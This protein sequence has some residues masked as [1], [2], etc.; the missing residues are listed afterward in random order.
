M[1]QSSES[2]QPAAAL[3]PTLGSSEIPSA[4]GVVESGVSFDEILAIETERQLFDAIADVPALPVLPTPATLPIENIQEPPPVDPSLTN[5]NPFFWNLDTVDLELN[6]QGQIDPSFIQAAA[7]TD[8]S[9]MPSIESLDAKN[10][11]LVAN[12]INRELTA[13]DGLGEVPDIILITLAAN[14]QE[15]LRDSAAT[16]DFSAPTEA[17]P[18][19]VA[20]FIDEDALPKENR[21]DSSSREI[22]LSPS[23]QTVDESAPTDTLGDALADTSATDPDGLSL[24]NQ[25]DSQ[26]AAEPSVGPTSDLAQPIES[27]SGSVANNANTN[28]AELAQATPWNAANPASAQDSSLGFSPQSRGETEITQVVTDNLVQQV[29]LTEQGESKQLRLQLHPA[30]LGQVILQVDWENDSLKV[31]LLASEMAATE[32]LNQNRSELV[33][34][35]A[36]EGIDFDSMEISYESQNSDF[37]HDQSDDDS[38]GQDIAPTIFDAADPNAGPVTNPVSLQRPTASL[39]ITV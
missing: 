36:E 11:N 17:N 27:P 39:D 24:L 4:D 7:T 12:D 19:T 32:I 26:A 30:E 9:R 22:P 1:S 5:A 20:A 8:A 28:G 14:T 21:G 6:S 15:P 16:S 35:L 23:T 34:A 31:K 18:L 29:K 25:T 33:A 10:D 37:D 3:I 2:A 38:N 13:A